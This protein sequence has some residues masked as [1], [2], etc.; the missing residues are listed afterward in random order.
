MLMNL[1]RVRFLAAV[2]HKI[3]GGEAA[4]PGTIPRSFLVNVTKN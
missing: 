3:S 2:I 4:P 1:W